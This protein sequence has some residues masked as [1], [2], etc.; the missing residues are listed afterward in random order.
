M[1]TLRLQDRQLAV[2]RKQHA[3]AARTR[4]LARANRRGL[5]AAANAELAADNAARQRLAD[6]RARR[7]V[8]CEREGRVDANEAIRRT[9]KAARDIPSRFDLVK[10]QRKG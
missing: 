10:R 6:Q 2:A 5:D 4:Q 9:R 1:P 7:V 8:L 3:E